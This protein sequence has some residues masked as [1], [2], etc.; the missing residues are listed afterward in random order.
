MDSIPELQRMRTIT[1]FFLYASTRWGTKKMIVKWA[2]RLLEIDE[3]LDPSKDEPMTRKRPRTLP[4]ITYQQRRYL[5]MGGD[6]VHVYQGEDLK[7]Y[8]ELKQ[9]ET[10]TK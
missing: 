9:K 3:Q 6:P 5:H 1:A 4:Y 7:L 8:N 2:S 10:E